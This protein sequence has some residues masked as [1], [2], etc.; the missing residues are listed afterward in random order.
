VKDFALMQAA[1]LRAL[2]IEFRRACLL[3]NAILL[4]LRAER[5]EAEAAS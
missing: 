5:L 1:N 3:T 2:A 4:E